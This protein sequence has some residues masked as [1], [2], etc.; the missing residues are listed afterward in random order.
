MPVPRDTGREHTDPAVGDLARRARML[1]RNTAGLLAP[2]QK[3]GL[4]NHQYGVILRQVFERIV[5]HDVAQRVGI[6]AAAPQDRLLPPGTGVPGR[7][8]WGSPRAK[9]AGLGRASSLSCAAPAPAA[10]QRSPS[11]Q[12]IKAAHQGSPSRKRPA[13]AA[14][15][16][17]A[18]PAPT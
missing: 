9:R 5:A 15:R 14:T 17:C 18:N 2:L 7:F 11:R 8:L 16:S 12:P 13:D 4:V 6:P 3:T 10:H 1:P